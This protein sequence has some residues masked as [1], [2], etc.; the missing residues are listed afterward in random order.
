MYRWFVY[1]IKGRKVAGAYGN[2]NNDAS[3]NTEVFA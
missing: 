3:S 2:G 1:N